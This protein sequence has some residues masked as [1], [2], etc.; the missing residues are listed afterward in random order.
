MQITFKSSLV[1]LCRKT[2][3]RVG[4]SEVLLTTSSYSGDA[5]W[6]SQVQHCQNC[7]PGMQEQLWWEMPF[8]AH[9]NPMSPASLP[10]NAG[11]KTWGP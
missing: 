9:V 2:G 7:A 10:A 4:T 5:E 11:R 6:E 8:T 3:R 1:I